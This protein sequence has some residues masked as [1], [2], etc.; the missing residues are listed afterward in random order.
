MIGGDAVKS[1]EDLHRMKEA[2]IITEAEFER[3]KQGILFGRSTRSAAK[4]LAAPST[5]LPAEQ[6]YFAWITL[7][8]CRYAD[9]AGRSQR[10]EFWMF[11]LI[12]VALFVI[13]T[14]LVGGTM[15]ADGEM[16]SAGSLVTGLIVLA[17]LG[18]FVPLLAVE[19][20]RLHDQDRSGWFVLLNLIPY[21][22]VFI[23]LALMLVDGTPGE[24][25]FGPDP[26]QR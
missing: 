9:F 8:L 22:G 11:Q 26:T 17:L 18:L 13:G 21:L 24:N 23:V 14:V 12:Y 15:S 25:R 1:I 19:V 20:R 3:A 4:D 5:G 6:D 16:S 2:G 7:P 10:K